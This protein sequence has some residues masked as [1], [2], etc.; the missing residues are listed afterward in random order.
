MSLPIVSIITPTKGRPEAL[1]LCK[2]YVQRQDYQGE[3][4]HIIEEGGTLTENL[5]KAMPK[6]EGDIVFIFEDDD[7]Y[8]SDWIAE[9]WWHL[10]ISGNDI[11]GQCSARYYHLPTQGY[12]ELFPDETVSSLSCTAFDVS[13]LGLLQA[14]CETGKEESV[15]LDFWKAAMGEGLNSYL[16]FTHYVHGM[17]GLP[18]TPNMGSGGRPGFCHEH[19]DERSSKLREW[20]GD[21]DA[22]VYLGMMVKG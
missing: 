9:G 18:G 20:V 17:K 10:R 11:V 15:D 14:R 21:A 4:Q 1:E 22:E 7:H 8:R 3:I 16:F 6:V 12:R 5:L 13:A 19:D 2:H